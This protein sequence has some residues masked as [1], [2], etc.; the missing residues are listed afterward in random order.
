MRT[1]PLGKLLMVSCISFAFAGILF[2]SLSWVVIALALACMFV[3]SKVKFGWEIRRMRL[4]VTHAILDKMVFANEPASIRVDILNKGSVVIKGVFEDV[5]KP[6][7]ETA[8]GD[9]RVELTVPPSTMASFSYSFVPKVRGK[10]EITGTR[11]ELEDRFGLLSEDVAIPS[12]LVVAAHTRRESFDAA[13]K[14]AGKEHFEYSGGGRAPTPVLREFEFDGIREYVAGDRARDIHWKSLSKTG[15]LMTKTYKKEGALQ[16]MIFVDCGR[17]MRLIDAEGRPK[18]DHAVDL[19]MQMSKVLLSSY[20]QVGVALFDEVSVLRECTPTLAKHHFDEIVKVLREAPGSLMSVEAVSENQPSKVASTP[21][22]AQSA[23]N[24][25]K[26]G[27]DFLSA[28][29]QLRADGKGRGIGLERAMRGIMAK[30][31]G[32]E[33]LF[34]IISDLGSSRDAVL[35]AA[36]LTERTGDQILVIHTY[37]DWYSTLKKSVD[38]AETER[39]YGNMAECLKVE[40]RLR[41][42]GSSYIRIGPADTAAYIIRSVRRGLA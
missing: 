25:T 7:A 9:K 39:L 31:K 26:E 18:I 21:S 22:V 33:L 35:T 28:V 37:D 23:S 38:V 8:A 14:I 12:R 3:N 4:K 19:T 30:R 34:I 2:M 6:E 10:H 27:G 32:Q 40:G 13:R 20:H 41:G 11:L 36:K 1:S 15:E 24:H 29:Q 16:T 42:L 5:I 17:S